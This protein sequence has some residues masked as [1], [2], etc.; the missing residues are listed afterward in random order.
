[1]L[2][3]VFAALVLGFTI[4]TL[5]DCVQTPDDQ[6]RGLPKIAWAVIILLFPLAGGGAWLLAGRPVR[7][8]VQ[9]RRPPRRPRGPDDDPDFLR[10]L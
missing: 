10:G 9:D 8:S 1:M 5:T 2:R 6:V 4:Y 3:V 7:P